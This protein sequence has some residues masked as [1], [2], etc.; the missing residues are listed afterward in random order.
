MG[1]ETAV[2]ALA[3]ATILGAGGSAYY[4]HKQEK[5]SRKARREQERQYAEQQAA[6]EKEKN[7]LK[8]LEAERKRKLIAA[9]E[10]VPSTILTSPAGLKN[11][12]S[13]HRK[14]LLGQ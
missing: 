4:G 9:G 3:G 10:R 14:T 7:R 11:P 1:I 6:I 8:N 2:L 12:P 5:E 13:V